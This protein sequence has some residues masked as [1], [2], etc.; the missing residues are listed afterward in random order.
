[1]ELPLYDI[2]TGTGDFI[3]NG[4]VSHNCFARPRTSTWTRTP[5][6]TS[7][8]EIVVKV[9]VPEVLRAE[10]ARPSWKGEQWPWARTPTHTSGSRAATSSCEESWRCCGTPQPML[11]PDEVAARAARPGSPGGDRRGDGRSACLSVPTLDEKAWRATEPHTP[12]PRARLE[13]VAEL[14]RAGIPT[15]VLIAPLMPGI[16]DAPE[17]VAKIV[18]LATEAAR[19]PSAGTRC[20]CAARSARCSSTGCASTGPTCSPATRSSTAA[21]PTCPRRSGARSSARPARPGSAGGARQGALEAP[22][23]RAPAR[24]RARGARAGGKA[25]ARRRA[26]GTGCAGSAVLRA[27]SARTSTAAG[28]GGA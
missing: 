13:A 11:D 8:G 1:M 4:V 18:E 25:A 3:A 16:N 24:A 20:S 10:V 12:S 22:G 23:P 17:Q 15:G 5:G 14:N 26:A 9:N 6:G 21:A 27:A 7:S 2:T 28:R 19:P